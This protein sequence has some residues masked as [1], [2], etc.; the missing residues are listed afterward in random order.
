MYK[1]EAAAGKLKLNFEIK[2][3]FPLTKRTFSTKYCVTL[4]RMR[5][6]RTVFLPFSSAHAKG[7]FYKG[8]KQSIVM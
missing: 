7:Q 2:F 4:P 1:Y 6:L 3:K 8:G 5:L